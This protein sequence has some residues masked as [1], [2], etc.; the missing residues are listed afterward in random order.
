MRVLATSVLAFEAIVV[1]LGIP[2][3]VRLGPAAGHGATPWVGALLVLLCI[4]AAAMV[5]RPVGVALGWAVQVLV[6]AAG[7]LVPAG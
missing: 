1:A 3:A 6:L 2:V 4:L 5:T 7:L